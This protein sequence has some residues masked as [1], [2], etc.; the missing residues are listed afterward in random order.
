MLCNCPQAQ[1]HFLKI[2][3]YAKKVSFSPD[4]PLLVTQ[5]LR[6][7]PDRAKDFSLMLIRNI[8]GP[9]VDIMTLVNTFMRANDIKNTTN[10]LLEYLKNRGDREEDGEL[11]TK[12]LEINLMAMPR[13]ADAIMESAEYNFTHYDRLK[14]AQ[15]CERAQLYQRALEHYTELEDIKRIL[16]PPAHTDELLVGL[17]S[18]CVCAG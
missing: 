14:I 5:L 4:Y 7:N 9:I 12:V 15:L 2:F 17:T 1:E 11:Q 6:V 16:V 13:V 3:Q 10:I 8:D 18:S